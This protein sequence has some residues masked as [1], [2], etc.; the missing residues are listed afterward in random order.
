MANASVFA[1]APGTK[2]FRWLDICMMADGSPLRVPV[3]TLVGSRPGPRLTVISAQHGYEISEIEVCRQIVKTTDP[4]QLKG[5]LTVVPI[6][7]PIT[8]EWGTRCTWI[9]SLYGDNGNMNRLWPGREDGWITD[10]IIWE[11]NENIVKGSDVVIDLHDGETSPPGVT[12]CYGYAGVTQDEALT[13]KNREIALASGIDILVKKVTFDR[14]GTL[15]GYSGSQGIPCFTCEIGEFYGF[16]EGDALPADEPTSGIPEGGV[17]ALTNIMKHLGMLEGA[18]Q[19]PKRQVIISPENNLRPSKGGLLI[20]EI[21]GNQIGRIVPQGTL[22]GTVV[23][24]YTFEVLEEIRA[25]Y[26]QNMILATTYRHPFVRVNPGNYSY[27]LADV[28]TAEWVNH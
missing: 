19:L 4:K 1:Q 12:I 23:S 15:S 7:S 18:L 10:R 8:F 16:Q 26:A 27:I 14:P 5:T 24:P 11:L 28:A 2:E 25:P 22:L 9:D 17:N 13:R 6:A 20:S 3:H 21:K